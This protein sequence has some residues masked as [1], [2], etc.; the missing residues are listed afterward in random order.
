ML[1]SK[2]GGGQLKDVIEDD[3]EGSC[4]GCFGRSWKHTQFIIRWH[5][6]DV[7]PKLERITIPSGTNNGVAV[8]LRS[9]WW[10][11]FSRTGGGGFWRRETTAVGTTA[12]DAIEDQMLK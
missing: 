3:I 2:R 1:I 5:I 7:L 11:N 9:T 12:V 6:E 10:H 8:G 4:T